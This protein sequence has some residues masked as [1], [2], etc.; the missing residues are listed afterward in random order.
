MGG[1][2]QGPTHNHLQPQGNSPDHYWQAAASNLWLKRN[3]ST[4]NPPIK[5]KS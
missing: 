1:L 3:F 4:L 2:D 5:N